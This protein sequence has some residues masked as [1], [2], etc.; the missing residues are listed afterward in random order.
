MMG[1]IG[2]G[3]QEF[4]TQTGLDGVFSQ[5]DKISTASEREKRRGRGQ[6]S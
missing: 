5:W 2:E 1:I 6:A 3:V 4:S